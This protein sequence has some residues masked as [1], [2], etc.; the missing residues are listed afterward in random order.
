MFSPTPFEGR[1]IKGQILATF[2]LGN[3]S[4]LDPLLTKRVLNEL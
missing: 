4:H 3:P 1:N 2:I